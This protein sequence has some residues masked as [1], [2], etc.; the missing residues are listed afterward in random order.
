MGTLIKIP[1]LVPKEE[2]NPF[3]FSFPSSFCISH[4]SR[5]RPNKYTHPAENTCDKVHF[6]KYTMMYVVII[7]IFI[8]AAKT[9]VENFISLQ[10]S[11]VV[12]FLL[13]TDVKRVTFSVAATLETYDNTFYKWNA[14]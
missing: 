5:D 8:D 7:L 10:Q 3:G 14:L 1:S 6:F 2:V 11:S 9:F 4:Q 13:S 12:V